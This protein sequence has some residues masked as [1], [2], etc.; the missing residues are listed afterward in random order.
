VIRYNTAV[1]PSPAVRRRPQE[2]DVS[3]PLLDL[4]AQFEPLREEVYDA[5]R[6]VVEAQSFVLGATVERFE[7]DLARYTGARHAV[8]CASGTDALILALAAR[9]IGPGDEVL[10]TP[11][12][13]FSTASCAYKVGA[14]P[15]FADIDERTFNLDPEEVSR[16][17]GPNTRAVLPVHLFGQCAEMDAI[18]EIARRHGIPVIEDAAQALGASYRSAERDTTFRAGTMGDVGCYS[19]FPSKNLGGFGDGGLAVTDDDATAAELR[20]LRVHGG[21]QMY[22]HRRVGWN[23]RLDAIQAAVLRVKLPYL[24]G[25]SRGRAANAERY[26]RWF[27][28]IGLVAAGHVRLPQRLERS[29][30]IFNQYTLRVERR[31]D[32]REHL[33][34]RGI[35]HSVYY[36]VPLHLQECFAELGYTAGSLPRA[37]Q[38]CREVIS[39]PV[40]PELTLGEQERV[41]GEIRAFYR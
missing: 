2:I 3:V 38:A 40:Y 4:K 9:G 32:L 14:R 12:S 36:P 37:E 29:T 25:W 5:I 41:V 20:L 19:F 1:G 30:H 23:S 31:D 28:D 22:E 8:G 15:A 26:D 11:F 24:D 33:R 13:F 27:E 16:A 18:V 39:L 6:E 35:G 34:A 7:A 10:T 17:I 21:R